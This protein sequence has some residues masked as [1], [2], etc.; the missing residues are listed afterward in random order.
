MAQQL[1]GKEV[2]AKM[3]AQLAP[4][5]DNLRAKGIDPCLAIVRV[6]ERPDDLSYERSAMKRMAAMK[7]TVKNIVMPEDVEQA[8]LEKIFKRVNDDPSVHGILLFQPLPKHLDVE[9]LKKMIHPLKDVDS[10]S[11]A[12]AA[13]VFAGDKTGFAP[14]TPSAVMEILAQ[15]GVELRGKRVTIVGRSMVVGKPLAMLMLGQNATP[16]ICHTKTVDLPARC[17]EA[18][19]LVACAG[20][21][22]MITDDMVADGQIVIDV[23]INV[24]E[25]GK[26]CGDVDYDSVEPHASMITPVPGGVGSVTT[27]ILGKHTIQAAYWLNGLDMAE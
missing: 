10:M 8:E 5:A 17:R 3:E 6:G 21:A 1:L 25:N 20:K 2:V 12:N 4:F 14:C 9:P 7:V 22:K 19:V 23:G 27:A 24:D 13:K 18:D 26:L 16:T 15:S 11:P